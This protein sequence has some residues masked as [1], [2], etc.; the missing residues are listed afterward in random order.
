[1]VRSAEV[2][3]SA[4][5]LGADVLPDEALLGLLGPV[6]PQIVGAIVGICS[7]ALVATLGPAIVDVIG[8]DP[9][10]VPLVV[11]WTADLAHGLLVLA[12]HGPGELRT[13]ELLDLFA[14]HRLTK[15][16][17]TLYGETID[18]AATLMLDRVVE[19]VLGPGACARNPGNNEA[20]APWLPALEYGDQVYVTLELRRLPT[21]G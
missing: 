5:V 3:A 7:D 14:N 10:L 11:P 6:D 19:H 18:L 9:R 12:S 21:A 8:T 20:A 2:A 13:T 4:E 1:M 15:Q 16:E 17:R